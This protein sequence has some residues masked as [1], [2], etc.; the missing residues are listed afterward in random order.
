MAINPVFH[1]LQLLVG[2]SALRNLNRCRVILFGVGGVGSWCAE[3]LVR[4]GVG[5]LLKRTVKRA[6]NGD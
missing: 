2:A 1:R 3:A 5:H 6:I 4:D